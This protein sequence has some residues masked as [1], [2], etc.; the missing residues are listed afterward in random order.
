MPAL[1]CR[2]RRCAEISEILLHDPGLREPAPRDA[3]P[4]A[5][6]SRLPVEEREQPGL[7]P[8]HDSRSTT[9]MVHIES[10][11]DVLILWL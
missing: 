4:A 10:H 1:R 7:N 8:I 9:D 2:W 11:S 6:L 3:A 5:A